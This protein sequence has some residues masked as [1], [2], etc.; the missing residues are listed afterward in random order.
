MHFLI[1]ALFL[2]LC[3]SCY[4]SLHITC[5][6]FVLGSDDENEDDIQCKEESSKLEIYH[7]KQTETLKDVQINPE[8]SE[9]KKQKLRDLLEEFQDIF[10]DVPKT[11]H[12][13]THEIKLNNDELVYC[14]P[15][16]VPIF[17]I[18]IIIII[19]IICIRTSST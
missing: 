4:V 16:K 2:V 17:I 3:T 9:D 10:S 11:T 7:T 1:Y 12:L 6:G 18:I 13:I 5:V 8:L 19:I 14:K 15:Y